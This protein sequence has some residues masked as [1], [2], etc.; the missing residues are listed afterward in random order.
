MKTE[1]NN[2][3][4]HG[5]LQVPY[6]KDNTSWA[7]QNEFGRLLVRFVELFGRI[8]TGSKVK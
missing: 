7:Q 6:N 5:V 4:H 2:L 1:I 3:R 8:R